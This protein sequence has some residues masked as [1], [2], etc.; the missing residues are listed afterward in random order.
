MNMF[1]KYA[2]LALLSMALMVVVPTYTTEM[3]ETIN[4]VENNEEIVQ[5]A[6][7]VWYKKPAVQYAL[8]AAGAIVV[9]V[10]TYYKYLYNLETAADK[11]A[12]KAEDL[13][14]IDLLVDKY[15]DKE[16]NCLIRT[17]ESLTEIY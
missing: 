7:V 2:R 11:A 13:R 3:N 9:C 15:W 5:P 6:Q 16:N 8:F 4:A 12:R 10:G 17:K 14:Q 1:K